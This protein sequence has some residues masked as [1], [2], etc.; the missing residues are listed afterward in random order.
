MHSKYENVRG[1]VIMAV[2][3]I[4]AYYSGQN[5]PDKTAEFLA[6]AGAF[7]GWD[8]RNAPSLHNMLKSIKVGDIIYIKSYTI[9]TKS[10]NIKAIGIVDDIATKTG[11]GLGTGIGVKWKKDFTPI[12]VVLNDETFRNN[13]YNNTLYEEFD[14]DIINRVIDALI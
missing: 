11:T 14:L 2:W 5:S 3:G 6:Q 10:L 12:S 1:V 13:V 7:V 9:K 8:Y 4:G